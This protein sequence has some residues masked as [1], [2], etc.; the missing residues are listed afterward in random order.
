[1]IDARD[2]SL[3]EMANSQEDFSNATLVITGDVEDTKVEYLKDP[4][5]N[6]LYYDSQY[7]SRL[8]T[9][10]YVF[11]NDDNPV[12][13]EN[14]N[15]KE[16]K[17]V[18]KEH[19]HDLKSNMMILKPSKTFDSNNNVTYQ[20][21]DARYLTKDLNA[22]EWKVY[23]DYLTNEIH[24]GTNT[25]DMSDQNFVGNSSGVAM[26]YKL[27]GSDQERV[28]TETLYKRGIIRRL[29]LLCNY[30]NYLSNSKVKF[31]ATD[32]S[33]NPANNVTIKFTPNLPKNEQEIINNLVS[34]YDTGEISSQ[35][36]LEG[37]SQITGIPAEQESQRKSD[38]D[39]T[40]ANT[41]AQRIQQLY[42]QYTGRGVP[43]NSTDDG[44]N[45]SNADPNDDNSTDDGGD[46]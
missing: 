21:T 23:V 40:N 13:D 36:F 7:G 26:A 17:P 25:P 2:K 16:N 31:D 45:P 15:Q 6:Q 10:R 41:N 19:K 43:D 5:G 1:M 32:Q 38:E 11:D 34:L 30:W 33:N 14:G 29:R 4:G 8:T 9:S 12:L 20:P 42:K 37:A 22:D 27:M 39:E 28:I 44:N 35:T 18:I 24:K 46:D 3:S